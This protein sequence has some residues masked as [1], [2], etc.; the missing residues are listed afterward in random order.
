LKVIIGGTFGYLHKGHR[1]LLTK[2]FEIGDSVYI[3][4]TTDEYV[5]GAKS[6]EMIPV[7]SERESLLRK[8]VGRF[9]KRFEIVPLNDRFGPSATGDFDA[10]V[11][12][13]ETLPVALEIN[14]LRS[15]S[16]LKP[17]EI[18]RI[19]YALSSDSVPISTSRIIRGEIDSEGRLVGRGGKS[20]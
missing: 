4:L 5:R 2:A 18:V 17:L 8:F 15:G 10:I 13:D 20:K 3:G 12:T 19:E 11:V 16:G 9:G 7:Y 6:S 1:K 14:R